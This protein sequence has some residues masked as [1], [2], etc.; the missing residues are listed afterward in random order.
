MKKYL[1]FQRGDDI[2]FTKIIEIKGYKY[3]NIYKDVTFLGLHFKIYKDNYFALNV[4][5]VKKIKENTIDYLVK[6][7]EATVDLYLEEMQTMMS[8]RLLEKKQ[9]DFYDKY[10]KNN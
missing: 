3:I 8:N 2:Y 7:S 10:L 5:M 9:K 6:I 1:K 4:A